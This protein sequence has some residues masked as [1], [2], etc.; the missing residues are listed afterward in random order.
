MPQ[1]KATSPAAEEV[2]PSSEGKATESTALKPIDIG[3]SLPSV[4]LK[5]EKDEDVDVSTLTSEKGL[6][7]FLVPKADTRRFPMFLL[8]LFLIE[9]TQ[10]GA[11]NKPAL[12]V[13]FTPTLL[14]QITTCIV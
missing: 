12:S 7:L 11:Q 9:L 5:N 1:A 8:T 10:L 2:A 4:I 14:R 13:I 6:V 3:D